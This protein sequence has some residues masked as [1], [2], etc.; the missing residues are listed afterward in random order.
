MQ[1]IINTVNGK[2]NDEARL[3]LDE[4]WTPGQPSHLTGPAT[5]TVTIPVDVTPPQ[6]TQTVILSDNI[7]EALL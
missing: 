6:P 5:P 3:A 4:V 2:S 7:V 1:N